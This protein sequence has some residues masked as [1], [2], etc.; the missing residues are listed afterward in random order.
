M[1]NLE[2]T[3]INFSLLA[4]TTAKHP[5][6]NSHSKSSPA[7]IILQLLGLFGASILLLL[8]RHIELGIKQNAYYTYLSRINSIRKEIISPRRGHILTSDNVLLAANKPAYNVYINHPATIKEILNISPVLTKYQKQIKNR[9][10]SLHKEDAIYP[11][12]LLE[13]I[14]IKDSVLLRSTSSTLISVREEWIRDYPTSEVT[15]H[16]IGYIGLPSQ[17]ELK[18]FEYLSLNDYVGKSGLERYY[19]KTLRGE[20]GYIYAERNAN[21]DIVSSLTMSSSSPKDGANLKL[22]INYKMQESLYK[23]LKRVINQYNIKAGSAII[24]NPYTGKVLAYAVYP[25]FKNNAFLPPINTE[26]ISEYLQNPREPLLNR[27]IAAQLPPGSTFKTIVAAAALSE[28]VITAN[29]EYESKGYITLSG[30]LIF[31]EFHKRKHGYINVSEALMVSSNVFFCKV[32]LKLGIDRFIPYAQKFGIGQK[33]GIDLPFEASGRLPTPE[34]KIKLAKTVAPWLEPIWYP[35][36]DS[37]NTAIGQGITLVTPIQMAKVAAIIANGGYPI[38]PYLVDQF[39][40]PDQTILT[41][42]PYIGERFLTEKAIQPV[43]YGM[44]LSVYGNRGLVKILSQLPVKIAAKT[45]TAEFGQKTAK[46]YDNTHGWL[47]GFYPYEKPQY[48]FAVMLEN[49]GTGA[50]AA[51][52]MYEFIKDINQKN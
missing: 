6:K 21:G 34:T 30:G 9:L 22:T 40:Y 31:Q 16:I 11:A 23:A 43:R 12:L 39:I 20:K 1:Q 14:P 10:E 26:L 47:I 38:K 32:M 50:K 15:A 44:Y 19:D 8:S 13:N 7:I 28:G 4:K 41:N 27:G 51:R 46:G 48:A 5:N 33:T 25:S 35:E 18:E 42:K 17:N 24:L 3:N 2:I 52:V 36:G 49:G 37:C 29:T 45:G